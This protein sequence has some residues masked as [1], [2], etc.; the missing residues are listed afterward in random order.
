VGIERRRGHHQHRRREW[1]DPLRA[2]RR[3]HSGFDITFTGSAGQPYTV[4][5]SSELAVPLSGWT[6]LGTG[7]F[8]ASSA[9]FQE[10]SVSTGPRRFYSISTP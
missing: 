4:R 8:T 1:L 10:G 6:A 5:A 2:A 9:V 3:L 7:T